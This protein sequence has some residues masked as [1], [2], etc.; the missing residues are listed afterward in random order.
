[1]HGQMQK[2]NYDDSRSITSNRGHRTPS[3]ISQMDLFCN[4]PHCGWSHLCR[5]APLIVSETNRWHDL[6]ASMRQITTSGGVQLITS[7][8]QI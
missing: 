1:M 7:K 8:S 2:S 3:G 6:P 4:C 5:V